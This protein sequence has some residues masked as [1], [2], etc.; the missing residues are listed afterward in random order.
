VPQERYVDR[1]PA[2]RWTY[3]VA[4]TANWKNDLSLGDI[5]IVST[6]VTVTVAG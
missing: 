3:R 1:A 6:P 2:G 4:M 5:M